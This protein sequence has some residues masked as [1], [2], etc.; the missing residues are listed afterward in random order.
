MY[1][2]ISFSLSLYIYIYIFGFH[3]LNDALS[4]PESIAVDHVLSDPCLGRT[5][6][7]SAGNYAITQR[8]WPSVANSTRTV[9][10]VA[11][12]LPPEAY[13]YNN[14]KPS[15]ENS[16]ET[17]TSSHGVDN[18]VLGMAM[19][20]FRDEEEGPAEIVAT[21]EQVPVGILQVFL[22]YLLIIF[23]CVFWY[24]AIIFN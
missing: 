1:T 15:R 13:S 9:Q 19:Q 21:W 8:H 20:P 6:K 12:T 14:Q 3:R 5:T 7:L 24:S 11:S 16:P 4:S 10:R 2:Y 18:A 23:I 17:S 22:Y